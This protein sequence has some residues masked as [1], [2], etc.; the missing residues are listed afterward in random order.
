MT[1]TLSKGSKLSLTTFVQKG[2]WVCAIAV[3]GM[4]CVWNMQPYIRLIRMGQSWAATSGMMIPQ[5]TVVAIVC[6]V[7]LWGLLQFGQVYYVVLSHDREAIRN[8]L[9]HRK[10]ADSLS[11]APDDDDEAVELKEAYN[12]VSASSIRTAKRWM[13]F[14]YGFDAMMCVTVYPPADSFREFFFLVLTGRWGQLNWPNIGL[15]IAMM[16]VFEGMVRIALYL[17]KQQVIVSKKRG[18]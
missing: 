2:M 6:G 16:F 9:A 1:A 14:A 13:W 17:K 15:I 8:L 18:A 5:S 10:G 12:R 4:A 3:G 11:I 7:L